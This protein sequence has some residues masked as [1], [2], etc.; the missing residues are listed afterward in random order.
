MKLNHILMILMLIVPEFDIVFQNFL[1]K[2]RDEEVSI[3][4]P[5]P[6]QK[7]IVMVLHC[8]CLRYKAHHFKLCVEIYSIKCLHASDRAVRKGDS[9]S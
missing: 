4:N 2:K 8:L 5:D 1:L 3:S 6:D 7:P 9:D